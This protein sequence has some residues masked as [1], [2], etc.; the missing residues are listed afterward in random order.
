LNSISNSN[1]LKFFYREIKK[2]MYIYILFSIVVSCVVELNCCITH[3]AKME[4]VEYCLYDSIEFLFEY[5]AFRI[6]IP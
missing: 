5:R 2:L 1:N 4:F 3:R 6:M